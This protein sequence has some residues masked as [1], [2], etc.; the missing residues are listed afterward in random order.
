MSK[1]TDNKDNQTSY[2]NLINESVHTQ[3]DKDI[4]DIYAV[5]KYF[6]VVK[7]GYIN[8]HY[9]YIP[10]EKVEGWDS[11][12]IWLNISE[13]EAEKYKKDEFPNPHKYYVK[14]TKNESMHPPPTVNQIPAKFRTLSQEY[15]VTEDN[16]D[17]DRYQCDL[18][19]T[20]FTTDGELENHIMEIHT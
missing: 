4:G 11:N 2:I 1:P 18:C 3:D 9:Y 16:E 10:H 6:L 14:G 15:A 19:D 7:K 13:K 17:A 8:I 5:S 20:I 12:V